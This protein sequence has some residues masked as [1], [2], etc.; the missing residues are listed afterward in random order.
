MNHDKRRDVG[1]RG[2]GHMNRECWDDIKYEFLLPVFEI[3][4]K[5]GS[6]STFKVHRSNK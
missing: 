2:K 3:L 1:N 5:E 4:G 6:E